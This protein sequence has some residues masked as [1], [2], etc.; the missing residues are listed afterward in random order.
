MNENLYPK[1]M[2]K[3]GFFSLAKNRNVYKVLKA[4]DGELSNA[5]IG[6]RFFSDTLYERGYNMFALTEQGIL[7]LVPNIFPFE[8]E[9]IG[10]NVHS[11]Y[12]RCSE[13]GSMGI[14]TPLEKTCGNC[15]YSE[16]KTYYDAET[17]HNY[18]ASKGEK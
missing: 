13:C 8:K 2:T 6:D 1:P 14:N 11:V 15:G 17:I 5:K 12:T 10:K 18:L 4:L 9:I 7:E 3:E 16:G